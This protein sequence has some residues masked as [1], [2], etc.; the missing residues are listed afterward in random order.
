MIFGEQNIHAKVI[1]NPGFLGPGNSGAL[2]P[3]KSPELRFQISGKTLLKALAPLEADNDVEHQLGI[4]LM[5]LK[6]VI[7]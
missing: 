3:A 1:Y 6:Y 4:V 7:G 2:R 5:K